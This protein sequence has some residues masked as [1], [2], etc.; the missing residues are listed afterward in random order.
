MPKVKINYANTIIYKIICKNI[1][2]KESYIGHTTDFTDRKYKHKH[3]CNNENNKNYNLYVYQF[4]RENGGWINWDMVEIEKIK[5]IDKFDATKKERYWIE[6][7]NAELNS[8]IPNRTNK[9]R[10]TVNKEIILIK[11]KEYR[12]ENKEKIAEYKKD[13]YELNKEEILEYHKEYYKENTEKILDYQK[14]Y[15]TKNQDKIKDYKKKYREE[16]IDKIKE[17]MTCIC[18]SI[19]RKD[20]INRHEQ[21]IK[22]IKFIKNNF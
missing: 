18:G 16:N 10:Y 8:V 19:C 7:Y 13:F 11:A 22:H 21:S 17:K 14:Q 2:I 9:E 12:E 4:I 15:S 5:C 3:S 1:N 6:F 20:S